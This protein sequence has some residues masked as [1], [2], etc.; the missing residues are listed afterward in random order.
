[1]PMA[2][3]IAAP[4]VVG[5]RRLRTGG[6]ALAVM[7]LALGAA[8][9]AIALVSASRTASYLAVAKPV[10]VGQVIVAEDLTTTQLSGGAGLQAIPAAQIA[11]V[12]G[13]HAA[14]SLVPGALLVVGDLNDKS[15][16][17]AGFAQVGLSVGAERLPSG[18]LKA[19][20]EITL[21][22]MG[23]GADAGTDYSAIIVDITA[24][25]DGGAL[26]HVAVPEGKV[27]GVLQ[28]IAAG[29]SVVLK[30]QD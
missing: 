25:P 28:G 23:T 27:L 9:S 22:V 30:A 12:V 5:N 10:A 8:L 20:D 16:L 2:G 7:L 15:L 13:K 26:M 21:I 19:G 29:V 3:P 4:R 24:K 1:M 14:V 11:Q 18:D 17:P 6:I